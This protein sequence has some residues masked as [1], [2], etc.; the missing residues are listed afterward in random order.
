[1][2]KGLVHNNKNDKKGNKDT[3]GIRRSNKY[4]QNQWQTLIH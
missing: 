3:N 1:M 4:D 2:Q